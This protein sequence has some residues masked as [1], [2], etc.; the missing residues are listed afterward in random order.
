[1]RLRFEWDEAKARENFRKH[2]IDFEEAREVFRDPLA[3]SIPDPG[4]SFEESRYLIL[5]LTRQGRAL[6]VVYTER[7]GTIRIITCR[8]ATSAERNRYEKDT[9]QN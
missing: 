2:G 1:M 7:G 4:H 6:V 9:R 5:G 8:R 3:T